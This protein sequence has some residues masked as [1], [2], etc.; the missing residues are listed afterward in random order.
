MAT[1]TTRHGMNLPL[2]TR[3]RSAW[4]ARFAGPA[5]AAATAFSAFVAARS[6]PPQQG[7]SIRMMADTDRSKFDGSLA[8]L[9]G[10]LECCYD[11]SEECGM[12]CADGVY[13]R[14]AINGAKFTAEANSLGQS[15]R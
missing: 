3:L 7:T 14:G 9:R 15:V 10:F 5:S 13:E 12:V 8:A 1:V 11:G 4:P 6:N 2:G